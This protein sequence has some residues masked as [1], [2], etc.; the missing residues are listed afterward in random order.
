[1]ILLYLFEMLCYI[2]FIFEKTGVFCI[3]DLHVYTKGCCC[4]IDDDCC[5]NCNATYVDD[6]CTCRRPPKSYSKKSYSRGPGEPLACNPGENQ[7]S[8]FTFVLNVLIVTQL[9]QVTI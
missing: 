7:S 1:M 3:I 9:Y 5:N 4:A 8:L 2:C 6:G